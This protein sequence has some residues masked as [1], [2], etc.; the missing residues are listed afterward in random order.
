MNPA[1]NE[2]SA[3]QADERAARARR[4]TEVVAAL[5]SLV[6]ARRLRRQRADVAPD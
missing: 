2:A 6:P 3:S 4:P 1:P 5:A